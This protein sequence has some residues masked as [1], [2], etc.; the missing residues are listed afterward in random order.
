MRGAGIEVVEVG[1]QRVTR[2]LFRT[3]LATYR[4]IK[5]HHPDVVHCFLYVAN[6]FGVPL[7][8]LSRAR[9]VLMS[10]RSL[11]DAVDTRWFFA[12]FAWLARMWSDAIVCNSRAVLDDLSRTDWINR[13]KALVIR[14]GVEFTDLVPVPPFGPVVILAIANLIDYKG[15]DVLIE[16]FAEVL[17][18]MGGD[19]ARLQLAGAGPQESALRAQ[20]A[21]L[22]VDN[23]VEFL[24]S[25][26]D[27]GALIAGSHFTVLPSYSEGMPNAVLES[28]A[29]GRA[30]IGTDVG[31]TSEILA[32]GGGILVPPGDSVRL[33]DAICGL[34]VDRSRAVSL[35]EQGRVIAREEFGMDEMADAT[36][37]LYERLLGI[38][39]G[40]A[41]SR[42]PA[43]PHGTEP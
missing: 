28:L 8:R 41:H 25:V 33:A 15:L 37:S 38:E 13:G 26:V 35:G 27:V 9:I 10:E 17:G 31:G 29:S 42:D 6:I 34:V 36:V 12:P 16:A 19:A 43:P 23:A 4:G 21:R 5:G 18:R 1:F 22:G 3:I 39:E 20:A 32:K 30:V 11:Q 2:Q 24:G 14:N 7:S 40:S